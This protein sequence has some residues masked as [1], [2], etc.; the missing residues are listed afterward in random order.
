MF[1][2][3]NKS[4]NYAL[5]IF[6]IFCALYIAVFAYSSLIF[7][8][9]FLII[10][11]SKLKNFANSL[12]ILIVIIFVAIVSTAKTLQGDLINYKRYFEYVSQSDLATVLFTTLPDLSIRSTEF[13]FKIYNYL[14]TSSGV[15][16][17]FYHSMSIAI[18]YAFMLMFS[19]EVNKNITTKNNLNQKIII[20]N[21]TFAILWAFLVGITFSLTSQVLKQYLA[22]AIIALAFKF[23]FKKR[24]FF[25]PTFFMSVAIF[26]HSSAA[27]F[28]PII[29][30]S[31]IFRKYII[32]PSFKII[33]LIISF[34]ASIIAT[35]SIEILGLSLL[36]EYG[37]VEEIGIGVTLF[38]DLCLL[39]LV[40]F[41][42]PQNVDNEK[43]I[44]F[45]AII[46]TFFCSILFFRDVPILYLRLYFF[47]EIFRIFMGI[48]IYQSF[49]KNSRSLILILFIFIGPIYWSLKLFASNWD[50]SWYTEF[51]KL[52]QALF[53]LF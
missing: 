9:I 37:G 29:I 43:V 1:S 33:L 8:P 3:N 19:T 4:L 13:L 21:S 20:Q 27:I 38:I 41:I 2:E 12:S 35:S 34:F 51:D 44:F 30:F 48:Y 47:M 52:I 28:I 16:F 46:F 39:I 6:S 26:F 49:S 18:I 15:D 36:F 10:I 45:K 5:L 17:M 25:L 42:L 50:Y 40:F 24:G 53:Q 32:S 7:I 22:I 14:F 23:F 11:V 31:Y